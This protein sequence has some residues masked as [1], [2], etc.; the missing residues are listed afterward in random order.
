MNDKRRSQ[1]EKFM[2]AMMAFRKVMDGRKDSFFKDRK[3]TLPQFR[4]MYMLTEDG[5]TVKEISAMMNVSSSAATQMIEGLVQ[6]GNL[7][8]E[9]DPA[10]RRVVRVSMTAKGIKDFE[11]FKKEHFEHIAR[12]LEGLT[13]SEMELLTVIPQKLLDQ[14]NEEN[15]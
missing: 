11:S 3:Y 12:M 4:L 8:R 9:T 13:D 10:D 6:S 2:T 15:N 14:V 7:H 1:V 5:K